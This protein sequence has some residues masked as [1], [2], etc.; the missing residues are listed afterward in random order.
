[1]FEGLSLEELKELK[2]AL[3]TMIAHRASFDDSEQDIKNV[4]YLEIDYRL[5]KHVLH[6]LSKREN[7]KGWWTLNA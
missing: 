1:M 7:N 6:E 3:N 2:R 4:E 5:L